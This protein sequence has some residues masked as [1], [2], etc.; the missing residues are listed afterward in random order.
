MVMRYVYYN[1]ANFRKV[2]QSRTYALVSNLIIFHKGQYNATVQLVFAKY[3]YCKFELRRKKTALVV[4]KDVSIIDF[5]LHEELD[6]C[7]RS[8]KH[9]SF[10]NIEW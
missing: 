5:P 3:G 10:L 8:S 1:T 2:G 6:R 4:A 7:T 9:S